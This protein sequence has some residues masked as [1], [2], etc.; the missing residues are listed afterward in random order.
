EAWKLALDDAGLGTD[1]VDHLIVAGTHDRAVAAVTKKLGLPAEKVADRLAGTVGNVGTAQ[2]LLLLTATL[3][4]LAGDASAA[5]K[6]IALVTLA[7]GVDVLV[8][9]TT[10]A[11][12]AYAPARPVARQL[13]AAGPIS[14]GK[15]LAWRGFLPVEPP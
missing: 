6:T 11:L 9:R 12:A 5:G 13:A 10:D 4:S 1:A 7:D 3:E 8:L 15:F 2:P 14:Y